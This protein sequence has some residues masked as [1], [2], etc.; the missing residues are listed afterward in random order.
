MSSKQ[1][2]DEMKTKKGKLSIS[3]SLWET[4]IRRVKR[5]KAS[6]LFIEVRQVRHA[7]VNLCV[8]SH[9]PKLARITEW[10]NFKHRSSEFPTLNGSICEVH[11][12][13]VLLIDPHPTMYLVGLE[14]GSCWRNPTY[15]SR[16]P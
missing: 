2:T 9:L 7:V 12:V 15:D 10:A 13:L 11:L 5:K 16:I 4:R 6:S 1:K 14:P 8:Q 3:E